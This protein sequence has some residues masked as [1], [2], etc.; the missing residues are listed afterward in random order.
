MRGNP[1]R[2][3]AGCKPPGRVQDG[4][5]FDA[6]QAGK[7]ALVARVATVRA[8]PQSLISANDA[9][10]TV[11]T[12]APYAMGM[13]QHTQPVEITLSEGRNIIHFV[14]KPESRG[15][16]IKEFSLKPLK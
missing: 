14:L 3:L 13:W 8:G 7:Y 2:A 12:P 15:V 5:E 6:P 10:Q 4:Y 16:T 11:E 1:G 9:G